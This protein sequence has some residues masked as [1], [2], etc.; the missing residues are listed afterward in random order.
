VFSGPLGVAVDS[1]NR[2]WII[3]PAEHGSDGARLVGIGVATGN[4]VKEIRFSSNIAPLGSFLQDLRIDPNAKTAYIA[5]ASFW[6]R[7]P[8][9]V[10]VDLESGKARR[11]LDKHPSMMPMNLLVRNQIKDMR[12]FGGLIEL[13]TGIDAIAVDPKG[14]WVYWASMNHDR[15]FRMRAGDLPDESLSSDELAARIVDYGQKPLSDGI[16]TDAAGGVLIT[17]VEHSAVMRRAP[18][19]QFE[20]LVKDKRIRCADSVNY[21]PDGYV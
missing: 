9:I 3:D 13:I 10:I 14:D 20:T 19:G 16:A 18:D 7:S 11:V 12:F 5:D 1:K 6:R 21:G 8:G 2:L 17:D 15:L 4:V